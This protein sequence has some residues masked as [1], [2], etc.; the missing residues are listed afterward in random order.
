VYRLIALLV[1]LFS[2]GV[3]AAEPLR[4]VGVP[5]FYSKFVPKL[6]P[7]T[8]NPGSSYGFCGWMLYP[9][10]G[11]VGVA[12]MDNK[13]KEAFFIRLYDE[14][15]CVNA[16][17]ATNYGEP[18]GAIDGKGTSYWY[19]PKGFYLVKL[20]GAINAVKYGNG[21]LADKYPIRAV[22]I[23]PEY[24]D[25]PDGK[26]VPEDEDSL[27]YDVWCNAGNECSYMGRIMTFTDLRKYIP[28]RMT[29]YCDKRFCFNED[30]RIA[31]INPKSTL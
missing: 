17:C 18:R 22:K 27:S 3:Q 7:C 30:Q 26:Y 5:V 15:V 31:G 2:F 24:N 28:P 10:E 6:A 8:F 21:P 29:L 1:L 20:A 13:V 11:E 25:M 4:Y 23:L 9:E 14:V 19:V 16:V 12:T